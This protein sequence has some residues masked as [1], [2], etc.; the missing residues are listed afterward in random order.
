MSRDWR[1]HLRDMIG[2]CQRIQQY[3][4]GLPASSFFAH[5]MAYDAIVRN[6]ELLGE[7]ARQIPPDIRDQTPQVA[8]REIVGLRN[9][10]IHS[11]FG[12]DDEILWDVVTVRVPALVL[13]LE[14]FAATLV[15]EE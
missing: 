7:A 11:Y 9:V 15:D 10:L 13:A 4:D 5:E 3:A 14:S 8:W 12:I 6:V 1:L 2:F